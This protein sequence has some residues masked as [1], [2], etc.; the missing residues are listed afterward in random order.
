[1]KRFTCIGKGKRRTFNT[2]AFMAGFLKKLFGHNGSTRKLSEVSGTK[3]PGAE[4][5][6][7]KLRKL[8]YDDFDL[9]VYDY[10]I[11]LY[12]EKKELN[13]VQRKVLATHILEIEVNNGGFDQFYFNNK[14]EF[15]DDAIA[16]LKQF[17]TQEFVDLAIQSKEIYL[18]DRKEY[19]LTPNPAFESLDD[20]FYILPGYQAGRIRFIKENLDEI[21]Q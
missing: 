20:P 17:A 1:M 10:L 16:G 12:F 19:L 15:I 5:I 7:K 13:E 9:A 3:D 8:S 14:F 11:T 2:G 18:R 4:L 6:K 21:I